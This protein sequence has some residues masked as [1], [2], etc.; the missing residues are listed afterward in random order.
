MAAVGKIKIYPDSHHALHNVWSYIQYICET[1][2]FILTG[3]VIGVDIIV[4][5][6]ITTVDWFK[7]LSFWILLI[8]IRAIMIG[9]FYP[10]LKMF[11]YGMTKR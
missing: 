7:M 2:I 11:G 8:I 3:I 4:E 9:T 5:S 10:L 1:L 6:T